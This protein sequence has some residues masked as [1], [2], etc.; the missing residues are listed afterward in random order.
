MKLIEQKCTR[1][2][3]CKTETSNK[4]IRLRVD[5]KRDSMKNYTYNSKYFNNNKKK[6]YV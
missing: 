5:L 3:I 2:Y 6:I 4:N 1:L